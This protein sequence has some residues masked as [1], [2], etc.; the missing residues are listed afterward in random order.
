MEITGDVSHNGLNLPAYPHIY[1][2]HNQEPWNSV[3]LVV[4]SNLPA[5]GLTPGDP[6]ERIRQADPALPI[7]VKRMDDVLSASVG[8]PRLYAAMTALFGISGS[9]AGGGWNLWCR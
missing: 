4:R 2:S 1:L 9:S 5:A 7:A 8:Q 6:R 3:S